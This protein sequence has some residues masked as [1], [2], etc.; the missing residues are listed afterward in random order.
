LLGGRYSV[1]VKCLDADATD[2]YQWRALAPVGGSAR[3][4]VTV[5]D[6]TLREIPDAELVS[7]K[8]TVVECSARALARGVGVATT[9]QGNCYEAS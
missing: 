8:R 6:E 9:E 3:F 4:R 2:H 1:F 7:P 5:S